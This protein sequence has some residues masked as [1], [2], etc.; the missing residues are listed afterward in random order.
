MS[1]DE[2]GTSSSS[3][4]VNLET[5]PA[6]HVELLQLPPNAI[7]DSMVHTQDGCVITRL[8][9]GRTIDIGQF[10]AG[11]FAS[12][13]RDADKKPIQSESASV[14]FQ[15]FAAITELFDGEKYPENTYIAQVLHDD[16]QLN[17]NIVDVIVS[18][19]RGLDMSTQRNHTVD[20]LTN[21]TNLFTILQNYIRLE[22]AMPPQERS[23]CAAVAACDHLIAFVIE[24]VHL[25]RVRVNTIIT[26]E[27]RDNF[28][29]RLV[30][31]WISL[32]DP[33]VLP[34]PQLEQVKLA[35][36]RH[37]DVCMVVGHLL[38]QIEQDRHDLVIAEFIVFIRK[39][40]WRGLREKFLSLAFNKMQNAIARDVLDPT[41]EPCLDVMAI[42]ID[43]LSDPAFL[44]LLM[45]SRV[46]Q[47]MLMMFFKLLTTRTPSLFAHIRV[48]H[49]IENKG[50]N[51]EEEDDEAEY[52]EPTFACHIRLL[53]RLAGSLHTFYCRLAQTE[54]DGFIQALVAA[55]D[56]ESLRESLLSHLQT[57]SSL[58]LFMGKHP[59]AKADRNMLAGIIARI[60]SASDK[61]APIPDP[62]PSGTNP[63][64]EAGPAVKPVTKSRAS[65]KR[66]LTDLDQYLM[67]TNFTLIPR[68]LLVAE[69]TLLS[70]PQTPV[71]HSLTS[72]T[73][74]FM[75]GLRST[76]PGRISV[77]P[78]AW[79]LKATRNVQRGEF[80]V[81][82]T[83]IITTRDEL[84]ELNPEGRSS[85]RRAAPNCV[86]RLAGDDYVNSSVMG[87][88]ARCIRHSCDPTAIVQRWSID[89]QIRIF[90]FATRDIENG[91]QV[92]ID[93]EAAH[94]C[95]RP[96]V[97]KCGSPSC[98]GERGVSLEELPWP[99]TPVM[100]PVQP[101]PSAAQPSLFDTA[102][103]A[104]ATAGSMMS[105]EQE[106]QLQ[107]Q[108]GMK[109]GRS[110]V[111]SQPPPMV[112][113][114][115]KRSVTTQQYSMVPAIRHHHNKCGMDLGRLLATRMPLLHLLTR[116]ALV[117]EA[118]LSLL[119]IH[120]LL[121]TV[122]VDS[123]VERLL[124]WQSLEAFK[125]TER[126]SVLGH[127]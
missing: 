111:A 119:T 42:L 13:E 65:S 123:L 98:S 18:Y 69:A 60:K 63:S 104:L 100:S 81:E 68:N 115:S 114:P 97:C 120:Y 39:D 27:M 45:A 20:A 55:H 46:H 113:D 32:I 31:F 40:S 75:G 118:D 94:I 90:I 79:S 56:T 66:K 6:A 43:I 29:A 21:I 34:D 105:A 89:N 127:V 37:E 95:H 82:Y 48:L 2:S 101:G 88:L 84:A 30:N 7:K 85:I 109:R 58:P 22:L 3:E 72:L 112:A 125:C 19:V 106:Q 12:L 36:I 28:R 80:L 8:P 86:I 57:F 47:D 53:H 62:V 71:P 11:S 78:V 76:A 44:S 14:F 122:R 110:E 83:G 107:P 15:F 108:I 126:L 52:G 51:E 23:L 24:T 1:D 5:F 33:N 26:V 117:V 49:N 50:E 17:L 25:I 54:K 59:L 77:Q 4:D 70:L 116:P 73:D 74:Q 64:T 61:L 10:V 102:L 16:D 9:S 67:A 93:F 121:S 91:E 35:F 124:T 41:V 92:T 99:A 103:H 96:F 38:S 87:S